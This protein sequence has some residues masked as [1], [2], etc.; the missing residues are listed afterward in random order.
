M[1]TSVV[2]GNLPDEIRRHILTDCFLPLT[3]HALSINFLF[4]CVKLK[5]ISENNFWLSNSVKIDTLSVATAFTFGRPQKAEQVLT[6][7]NVRVVHILP[8]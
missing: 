2:T 4:C 3:T 7:P 8:A 6:A 1:N 5:V